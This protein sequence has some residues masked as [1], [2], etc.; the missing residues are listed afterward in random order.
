MNSIEHQ[1]QAAFIRW[2]R[3]SA[4][5]YPALDFAYAIPNGGKRHI[6]VARKLKAEGQRAGI[7]DVCIPAARRG[8]HAMYVEF[9]AGKNKLTD[10]QK[11]FCEHLDG[12]GYHHITA[13]DWQL[14]ARAVEWYL[15]EGK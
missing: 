9:K 6:A 7:L 3:M 8:Y 5:R 4:P 2:C 10:E 12:E 1:H 11:K 15:G 13:Y 14:A